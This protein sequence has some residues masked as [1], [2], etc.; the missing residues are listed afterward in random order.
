MVTRRDRDRRAQPLPTPAEA[1][2]VYREGQGSRPG[3]ANPYAGRRVL[4]SAW[5]AGNREALRREY[6][7]WQLREAERRRARAEVEAVAGDD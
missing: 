1:V 4:G 2:E 7:A 3:A 5:A 6:A